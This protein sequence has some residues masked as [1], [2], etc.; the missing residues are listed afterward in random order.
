MDTTH[1]QLPQS[2]LLEVGIWTL[3]SSTYCPMVLALWTSES[4]KQDLPQICVLRKGWSFRFWCFINLLRRSS[5]KALTI[6]KEQCRLPLHYFS[7]SRVKFWIAPTVVF[8]SLLIEIGNFLIF[9]V[10]SPSLPT[11]PSSWGWAL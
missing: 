10:S 2:C 5:S 11:N 3:L 8:V 7:E 9:L 6:F 4:G 1:P